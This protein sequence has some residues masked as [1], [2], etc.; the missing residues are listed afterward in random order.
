MGFDSMFRMWY[1][2]NTEPTPSRRD[3]ESARYLTNLTGEGWGNDINIQR[4]VTVTDL[5]LLQ[6]PY[7]TPVV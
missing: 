3:R 6:Y 5:A 7:S 4:W 2:D 1:R